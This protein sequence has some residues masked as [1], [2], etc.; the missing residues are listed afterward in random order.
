[1][2]PDPADQFDV[3][4]GHGTEAPGSCALLTESARAGFPARCGQALFD[5]AKLRVARDAR[6]S[7][8]SVRS[9]PP[10]IAITAWSDRSA[11]QTAALGHVSDGPPPTNLR[12]CINGIAMNFNP[13]K[14]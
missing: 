7:D 13:G 1:M 14:P 10:L 9:G 12:Y 8:R 2:A 5:Y 4:R 3:M 11:A 6:F